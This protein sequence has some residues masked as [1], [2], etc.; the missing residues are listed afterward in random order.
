[1]AEFVGGTWVKSDNVK[2]ISR[3]DGSEDAVTFPEAIEVLSGYYMM[4]DQEIRVALESG[5]TMQTVS[6]LY[7]V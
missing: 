3:A 2:R 7:R 5:G 4:T 6:F 1:M